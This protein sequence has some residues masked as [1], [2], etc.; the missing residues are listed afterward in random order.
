M[1]NKSGDALLIALQM[2]VYY[3]FRHPDFI[4]LVNNFK[5][6]GVEPH[7]PSQVTRSSSFNV[8]LVEIWVLLSTFMQDTANTTDDETAKTIKDKLAET[9]IT[10]HD[11]LGEREICGVSKGKHYLLMTLFLL[12]NLYH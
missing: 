6:H 10:L 3:I 9:L 4:P 1:D 7:V 11:E 2:T 8:V 12:P 5:I